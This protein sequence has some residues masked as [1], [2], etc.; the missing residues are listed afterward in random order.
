[1]YLLSSQAMAPMESVGSLP[2]VLIQMDM[3]PSTSTPQ[4]LPRVLHT[5]WKLT[6]HGISAR[7]SVRKSIQIL[8][9]V[10]HGLQ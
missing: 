10:M 7:C 1:M 6:R 3:S 8:E 5:L 2:A 4:L 9:R